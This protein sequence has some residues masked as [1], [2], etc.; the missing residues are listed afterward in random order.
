MQHIPST[1]EVSFHEL[2]IELVASQAGEG[3]EDDSLDWLRFLSGEEEQIL[4][5]LAPHSGRPG[6]GLIG[7][8]VD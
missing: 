4:Q 1:P 7:E 6:S 2:G 8:H 5:T 3:P